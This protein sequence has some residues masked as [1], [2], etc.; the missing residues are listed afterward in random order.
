MLS[1]FVNKRRSI[2]ELEGHRWPD[3]PDGSTN[4]VRSVHALRK[5]PVQDLTEDNVRRLIGQRE[6]LPW[7]LPLALDLLR[8]SATEDPGDGYYAGDLLSAILR[9]N[10]ETWRAEPE[11]ARH[12][13]ETLRS[14]DDL[15]RAEIRLV[16]AFREAASARLFPSG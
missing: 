8:A 1:D 5:V 12:L 14:L 6:G 2:E 10:P 16:A 3:A 9:T 4:L 13:D 7:L 15:S 11:W